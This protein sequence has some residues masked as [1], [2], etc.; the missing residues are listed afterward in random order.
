M[1]A[2]KADEEKQQLEMVN[3]FVVLSYDIVV[4]L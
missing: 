1:D 3:C 4:Y 2:K